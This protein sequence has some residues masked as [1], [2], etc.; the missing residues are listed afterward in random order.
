MYEKRVRPDTKISPLDE[1]LIKI[2]YQEVKIPAQ[3]IADKLDVSLQHIYRIIKRVDLDEEGMDYVR[4]MLKIKTA[5]ML[6]LISRGK[7]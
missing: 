3:E 4:C 5:Q 1:V 6:D 7:V 2:L